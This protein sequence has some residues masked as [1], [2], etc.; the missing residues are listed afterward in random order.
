MRATS[1]AHRCW[2]CRTR[3]W[4]PSRCARRCAR[5]A[6]WRLQRSTRRCHSSA[7]T[8]ACGPAMTELVPDVAGQ[9]APRPGVAGQAAPRP[10][11]AGQAAPGPTEWGEGP[12][13][14]P[15][16]GPLPTDARYDQAL[17]RGGD[18][19]NVVDAYR[20]WTREAIVADIDNR[21]HR[22]H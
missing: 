10:D 3:R 14:G 1:T 19:R 20:Y 18:T 22:L 12:G 11:V 8:P 2:C 4:T 6:R 17:L 21:R 7:R 5:R 9:A 16:Q 15:W 13:V